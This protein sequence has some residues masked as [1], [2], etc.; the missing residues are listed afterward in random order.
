MVKAGVLTAIRT[1]KGAFI[2]TPGPNAGPY[3]QSAAG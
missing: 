2:Y 1:A 3:V